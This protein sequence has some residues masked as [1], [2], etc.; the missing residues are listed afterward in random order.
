[1]TFP[2]GPTPPGTAPATVGTNP[3]TADEINSII[4]THLK[5]FLAAKAAVDQ[6]KRF[7]DATDFKIAPYY[8]T[9]D[10]EGALKAAVTTLQA[11][12]AGIDLTF[13]MR[14]VGLY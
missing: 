2:T 7:C 1:M 11:G 8:F 10:Q 3:R 5:G 13:V 12:M 4:G 9:E 6:D 14:V